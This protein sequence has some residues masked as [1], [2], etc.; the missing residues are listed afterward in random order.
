MAN[1]AVQCPAEGVRMA[2]RTDRIE[3]RIEPERA[4]R[5]RFASRLVDESTSAFMVRAAADRAER[6]IA[7]HQF[8]EVDDDYFDRLLAA[9]DEPARSLTPLADAARRV[10]E[11]P[12]FERR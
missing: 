12:A 3:A 9:L 5:I 11:Q 1:S 7:E 8:T 6:V 4:E 10:A 2:A